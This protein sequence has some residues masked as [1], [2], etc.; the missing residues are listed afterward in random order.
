MDIIQNTQGNVESVVT[1]NVKQVVVPSRKKGC[2]L[3]ALGIFVVFLLVVGVAGFQVWAVYKQGLKLAPLVD[4]AQGNLKSQDLLALKDTLNQLHQEMTITQKSYDG[5]LWTGF[6]PVVGAYYRDGKHAI[7]AGVSGVEA[8]QVLANA[9]E[10]YADILGFKGSGSFS[11]GTVEDRVITI[12]GTLE[13][14][15]PKIDDVA[16]KLKTVDTELLQIDEKRYNVEFKGKNIADRLAKV[17]EASHAAAIAVTDAKPALEVLPRLAGVDGE[18]KYMVL[19][20]NDGEL[21]GTGGFMTAYGVLRVDHGRIFPEKS[22]DIY[23]LDSKFKEH[24][25]PPDPIKT[26]LKVPYWYLRDM[27]L[28]PDFKENMDLFT[29]YYEK[30][31]GEPKIDGVIGVDTKFLVDLIK[32]V[33]P[34][35]V[36]GFGRFS[37]DNEP[38]CNCPQVVY[39]LELLTDKPLGTLVADRKGVLAPLM[40]EIIAKIYSAPKAW[41]DDIFK[42]I[43]SDAVAKHVVFYFHDSDFQNAAEK[44]NVAGRMQHS[45]GEYLMVNDVNFGGAKANIFVTQSVVSQLTIG[46]DGTLTRKL[47]VTYTN[48]APPSNC[49]KEAGQLCLNAPMPDYVRVYVPQGSTLIEAIGFDNKPQV[50]EEEGK[51]VF[52][53][54]LK[55]NPQS[56]A[57]T[58]YTYTLPWKESQAPNGFLI[59]EQVGKDESHY[60]IELPKTVEEFDLSGDKSFSIK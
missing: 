25:Q 41:W 48:P 55:I 30:I 59:Q 26:Y 47:T 54:F 1:P 6:I 45:D 19:F 17:K 42:T 28:S 37:D 24:L 44:L 18:K 23:D 58:I 21:R 8:G 60:K 16:L 40:R 38:R 46:N 13:K 56:S 34:I 33:G 49:N 57:K 32:I 53:G 27:N 35:D 3:A 36:P 15:M 11:G 20:H 43:I 50:R 52:E 12:L 5:L 9:I 4:R 7:A 10:P 14:I 29:S 51:T 22:S 31:P 2:L 39:Q